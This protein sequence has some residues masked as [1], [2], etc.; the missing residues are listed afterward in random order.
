[1][2]D[3]EKIRLQVERDKALFMIIMGI[4]CIAMGILYSVMFIEIAKIWC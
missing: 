2:M 1:M 3:N 4:F